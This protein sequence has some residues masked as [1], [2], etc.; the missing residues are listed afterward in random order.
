MD[1][2]FQPQ[3]N[4]D[5]RRA[6]KNANIAPMPVCQNP[7][8]RAACEHDLQLFLETYFPAAFPSRW[9]DDHIEVVKKIEIAIRDGCFFSIA[10]P[11]GSGKTTITVR[12]AVWAVL[13][14]HSPYVFLAA[15]DADKAKRMLRSIK[16]EIEFNPLIFADFP[17]AAH[18]VRCL[19]GASQAANKQHLDGAPTSL[20]WTADVAQFATIEGSRCSGARIGVG[21]I[22]AASRG[23]Q[24]T[25]PDGRVLRPTLILVD[26]FQTRESAASDVQSKTRLDVLIADLGGMRPPGG[27]LAI[28][29]TCTVIYPNDAADRLL[30]RKA[31]PE[32]H[33]VRKKLIYQWPERRDLW[34]DYM[35]LRRAAFE[36]DEQPTEANEFYA[37]RQEEMDRGAV[38]GWPDRKGPTDLSALQ[39][40]YNLLCDH[41]EEA[42]ASEYQNEPMALEDD[43]FGFLTADGI[44]EKLN[45]MPKGHL[46]AS[47][48]KI[49]AAIDVQQESLW[50]MIVAWAEGFSGWVLDYGCYPNQKRRYFTKRDLPVKLSSL[51]GYEGL[52]DDQAIYKGLQDLTRD[53]LGRTW[54]LGDGSAHS[55]DRLVIDEGFKPAT[56]HMF[57]RQ[58]GLMAGVLPIKGM[59]IRAGRQPMH[60]WPVKKGERVGSNW[61]IRPTVEDRVIRHILTDT[62]FWKAFVHYRLAVPFGGDGCLSLW[63]DKPGDHRLIAQHL[64]SETPTRTEGHGRKLIEWEIKP[65]RPDNEW[66]DTL[67]Y[68]ATAASEQ[69]ITLIGE[70]PP[71]K[72]RRNANSKYA[73]LAE[74]RLERRK[75]AMQQSENA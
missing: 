67:V 73:S 72:L 39:H 7:E 14:G 28:L 57:C 20:D 59:G 35:E 38:V 54:T 43:N 23:A 42:F 50:Y 19:Q 48:T 41:G 62:N 1:Q 22:T 17:E 46:P 58:D 37:Q 36:R 29:A 74:R 25:L 12:A 11:R 60:E 33:G 24:V 71:Q 61:R 44:A 16:T 32:W 64:T 15:A 5:A 10:M 26:D 30:N 40:A 53:L 56:V 45:R 6:V 75:K 31:Y 55:I 68:C 2:P 18:P 47:V 69:G 9:S 63:G 21:G 3:R 8:R 65:T 34:E 4:Y 66:L 13:Y 70:G 51:P 52:N 27:Q 49:T